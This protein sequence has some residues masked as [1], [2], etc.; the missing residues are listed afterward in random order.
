VIHGV[1][2]IKAGESKLQGLSGQFSELSS[3][4][5]LIA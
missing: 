4:N 3:Q 1:W 5:E 2:E